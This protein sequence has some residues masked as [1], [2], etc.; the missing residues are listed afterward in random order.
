MNK[1]YDNNHINVIVN[2]VGI[3][4]SAGQSILTKG[5]SW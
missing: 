3:F 2:W 5:Q 4:I 1:L